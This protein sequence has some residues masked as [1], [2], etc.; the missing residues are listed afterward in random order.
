MRSSSI[1]LPGALGQPRA[2]RLVE[3]YVR[4]PGPGLKPRSAVV[5]SRRL[6][7]V[8]LSPDTHLRRRPPRALGR[9]GAAGRDLARRACHF[10]LDAVPTV[11]VDTL[12]AA[13]LEPSLASSAVASRNGT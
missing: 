12:R 3:D 6:E 4:D 11:S 10:P 8:G 13:I 2:F 5:P 9:P 1:R 7:L